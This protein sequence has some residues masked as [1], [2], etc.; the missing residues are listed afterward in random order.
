MNMEMDVLKTIL[1]AVFLLLLGGKIKGKFKIFTKYCIPASV[2]GGLLFAILALLFKNLGIVTFAFDKGI[3]K[4]FMNVFF[5]ASGCAAGLGLLKTG[6]KKVGIF[7]VLAA[8]LAFLQNSVAV[9]VGKLLNVQPLIALMTGSVPMTGGHGNSAAF[10]PI[11]EGFGATGAMSVAIAAATFGLCA[12]SIIGGPVGNRLVSKYGLAEA[13]S[14]D[15]IGNAAAEVAADTQRVFLDKKRTTEAVFIVL[16]SVGLGS[17]IF[18]LAKVA[19]PN[20]VL[21]IHVMCM[22]AGVIVRNVYDAIKKPTDK[23][24]YQEIDVIGEVSLGLFVTMAIMSMRLWELAA[25]AVPM[26]VLLFAQILL[27]YLFVTQV[28]FRAMGKDYDAAVMAVGH[29]GFGTGAVPVSMTTMK[30]V[31]DKYSYSRIA[32]FV[33]PIVGGLIS[34]FTNSAIITAFLNFFK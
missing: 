21:P 23:A 12:G 1:F 28:T 5:A 18:D 4:L 25:L 33:V 3:Q 26:M 17:Y 8:A 2:I 19:L 31:C 16:V 22:L 20:V 34:N 11:A 7:V 15:S 6:G 27:V 32:F 10:A 24:I 14:K 9:G 30:T 29:L 13:G